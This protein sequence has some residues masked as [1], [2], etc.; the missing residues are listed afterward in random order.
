MRPWIGAITLALAA[1]CGGSSSL[2]DWDTPSGDVE[3]SLEDPEVQEGVTRLDPICLEGAEEACDAFDSD[4]DGHIDEGCEGVSEAPLEVAVAWN[5]GADLDLV[6]EAPGDDVERVEA[7]GACGD[8]GGYVERATLDQLGP[9]EIRIAVRR[10]DDCDAEGPVTA[11]VS[12]SYQGRSVGVF[13]RTLDAAETAE[14][15]R[16]RLTTR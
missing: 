1:G 13:N 4:C 15:T 10:A 14:I 8:D 6:V 2:S 3:L 9:G 11:S 12:V 5:T 16:L 7:N